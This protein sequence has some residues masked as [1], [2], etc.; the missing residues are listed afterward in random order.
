[1]KTN[2]KKVKAEFKDKLRT[3]YRVVLIPSKD[4]FKE[5][6]LGIPTY[7]A[8]KNIDKEVYDRLRSEE[9]IMETRPTTIGLSSQMRKRQIERYSTGELPGSFNIV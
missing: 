6:D 9:E 5:I 4:G 7:G 3:L 1:M 2:L 8:V